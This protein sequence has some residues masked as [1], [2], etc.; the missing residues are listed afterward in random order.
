MLSLEIEYADSFGRL[1][2]IYNALGSRIR[3]RQPYSHPNSETELLEEGNDTAE[4]ALKSDPGPIP[5]CSNRLREIVLGSQLNALLVFLPFGMWTYLSGASSLF[6]FICNG[7]TIVPLSAILTEATERIAG[8][9][10][11]TIG[12][13]L[14]ISLGNIVELIIL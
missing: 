12:A 1:S 11:D 8:H 4:N 9:A 10:G 2:R 13:L 6:I 7:L 14:N 3:S 5:W